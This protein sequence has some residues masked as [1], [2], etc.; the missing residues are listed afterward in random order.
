MDFFFF[1]GGLGNIAFFF[2]GGFDIL[3]EGCFDFQVAKSFK[4][5]DS[6]MLLMVLHGKYMKIY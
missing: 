1:G 3:F 5:K 6:M 4:T 2:R